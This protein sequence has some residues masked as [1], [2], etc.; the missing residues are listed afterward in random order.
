MTY[1]V[2]WGRDDTQPSGQHETVVHDA[3]ELDAVLDR[4]ERAG[5]PQLVDISPSDDAHAIPYGLQIGVGTTD[6]SFAIYIGQPAGGV[7]YDPDLPPAPGSICFDAG[8]E[9][10]DYPPGKL[11]LTPH[12]VRQ[13]AREYVATGQRP[14]NLSW[15]AAVHP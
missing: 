6:R 4:I 1:L 7:G 11:R 5:I 2:G 15:R 13:A 14:T 12:Q 8:G 3:D 10:T 9:P